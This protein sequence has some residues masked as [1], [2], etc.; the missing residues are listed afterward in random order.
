MTLLSLALMFSL[1]T[2]AAVD[3]EAWS[4]LQQGRLQDAEKTCRTALAAF[5]TT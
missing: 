1:G 2:P 3:R 5:E 4:Y